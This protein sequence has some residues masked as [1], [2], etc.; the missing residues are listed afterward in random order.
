MSKMPSE[1]W[2]LSPKHTFMDYEPGET[3][4]NNLPYKRNYDQC[5]SSHV[6]MESGNIYKFYTCKESRKS[7]SIP[8][9]DDE[10]MD[11]VAQKS[12]PEIVEADEADEEA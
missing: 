12:K 11:L 1:T 4:Y 6:M 8:N 3:F 5:N 2:N 10:F 9:R 7:Y